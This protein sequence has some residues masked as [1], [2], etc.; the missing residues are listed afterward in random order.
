MIFTRTRTRPKL[1]YTGTLFGTGDL[2][3]YL[4]YILSSLSAI[5]SSDDCY[6]NE[7]GLI[8]MIYENNE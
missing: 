2:M 5:S 8:E 3:I 1:S 7:A 4:S 6:C